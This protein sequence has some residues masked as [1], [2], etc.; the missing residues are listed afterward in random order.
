MPRKVESDLME[1]KETQHLEVSVQEE[2]LQL[3]CSSSEQC[4]YRVVVAQCQRNARRDW[5]KNICQGKW[6][7][8]T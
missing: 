6:R 1:Q 5:E 3:D 8:V 4:S 7:G 2:N